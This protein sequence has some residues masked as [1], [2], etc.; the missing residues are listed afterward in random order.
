[1]S[2]SS[3]QNDGGEGKKDDTLAKEPESPLAV[4][5]T[6]QKEEKMN[7]E[8]AEGEE[9]A[10]EDET[11]K[12]KEN[13]KEEEAARDEEKPN[14]ENASEPREST[15]QGS[16]LESKEKGTSQEA[17]E[18]SD[19]VP[20]FCVEKP[21]ST[22]SQSTTL[23]AKTEAPAGG[24][25][26]ERPSCADT[27]ETSA[28]TCAETSEKSHV[29]G[30]LAHARAK[31]CTLNR[32][33]SK[34]RFFPMEAWFRIYPLLDMEDLGPG[35]S[36]DVFVNAQGLKIATYAWRQCNKPTGAAVL[37]HSYTSYALFDFL[38]HQPEGGLGE[39]QKEDATWVPKFKGEESSQVRRKREGG[40]KS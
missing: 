6:V 30:R 4:E 36:S 21:V 13:G 22:P 27:K 14:E 18:G 23:E 34:Q 33:S 38:R 24:M 12:E 3:L 15:D 29:E 31:S 8:E 19:S 5:E 20:A 26:A 9:R 1:M 7:E 10:K 17:P 37:F 16:A 32:A 39:N 40:R 2:S 11:P 35:F 28:E 25:Q